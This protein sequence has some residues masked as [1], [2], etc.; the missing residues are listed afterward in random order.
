MIFCYRSPNRLRHLFYWNDLLTFCHLSK[1]IHSFRA[2]T[3]LHSFPHL[4]LHI[5]VP[6]SETAQPGSVTNAV[7]PQP[8]SILAL[9]SCFLSK[10][11][12]SHSSGS[13]W[14]NMV[15]ILIFPFTYMRVI[16]FN[17]NPKNQLGLLFKCLSSLLS[18]SILH[19]GPDFD[20]LSLLTWSV[21]TV[22]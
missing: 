21:L 8:P 14:R 5:H 2:R 16:L 10:L 3:V 4:C 18:F 9:F 6:H 19:L 7:Y 1:I 20:F 22:L 12:E 13:G 11:T 15:A 17:N